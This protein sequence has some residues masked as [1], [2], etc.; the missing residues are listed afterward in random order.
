M[1][2]AERAR[3]RMR[4]SEN[5]AALVQG[6]AHEVRNPLFALQVNAAAALRPGLP[7]VDRVMHVNYIE[8]QVRRLDVLMKDILAL[9]ERPGEGHLISSAV[10]DLVRAA[11]TEVEAAAPSARGKIRVAVPEGLTFRVSTRELT[12]TLAHLLQNALQHSPDGS[13]IEVSAEGSADAVTVRVRDGGRGLPPGSTERLFDPF[14]TTR[15]GHRGSGSPSPGITSNP[16]GDPH[17]REQQTRP[18]GYFHR[19]AAVG[20]TVISH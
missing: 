6:L 10:A 19:A 15:T 1:S 17:R 8:E 9:G 2:L 14:W 5:L 11:V 4:S 12:M 16:R 13:T 7:E 18:W 20:W 3:D